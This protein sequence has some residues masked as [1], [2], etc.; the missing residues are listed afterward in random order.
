MPLQTSPAIECGWNY[1]SSEFVELWSSL[2]PRE[3]AGEGVDEAVDVLVAHGQRAGAE[4]ALGHQDA[5]VE[6]AHEH[7]LG[8]LGVLRLRRAVVGERLVG[9]VQPEER[10]DARHLRAP[11]R[12]GEQARDAAAQAVTERL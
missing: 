8:Q 6:H 9:P 10:A 11:A 1:S 5:L 3:D 2:L 12:V 4:A 7:A